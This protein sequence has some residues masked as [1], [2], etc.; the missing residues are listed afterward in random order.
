MSFHDKKEEVLQFILTRHGKEKL[1]TGHFEPVYYKFV[2]DDILYNS[3]NGNFEECQSAA[4]NRI[5]TTPKLCPARTYESPDSTVRKI[6]GG[7]KEGLRFAESVLGNAE[8]GNLYAPAV[9][10][11]FYK[12]EL[13]TVEQFLEGNSHPIKI[14]QLNMKDPEFVIA[15]EE[16]SEQALDEEYSSQFNEGEYTDEEAYLEYFSEPF[17]DGTRFKVTSDYILLEIMEHNT[18]YLKEN[19]EFELF[20]YDLDEETNETILQKLP[21]AKNYDLLCDEEKEK[22][23]QFYLSIKHDDEIDSRILCKHVKKQVNKNIFLDEDIDCLDNVPIVI[24]TSNVYDKIDSDLDGGN[25][26]C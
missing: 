17:D 4:G 5:K 2:D 7:S 16:S 20:T 8:I 1:A 15:L 26:I 19:F 24:D 6:E 12:G 3:S 22:Y 10:V 18:D 21:F 13:D 9:E 14:A 11:T 23:A 25:E